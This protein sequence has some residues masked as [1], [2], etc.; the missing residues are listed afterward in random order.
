MIPGTR[1]DGQYWRGVSNR[2]HVDSSDEDDDDDAD[3]LRPSVRKA[4]RG[5]D[6]GSDD[7]DF[8]GF[9]S[10]LSRVQHLDD[11]DDVST[12][13]CC[14][15]VT[16]DQDDAWGNF[17]NAG[18]SQ[19]AAADNANP[20]DDFRP[21]PLTP[22]DW[23][24]EFDR[25]FGNDNWAEGSGGAPTIVVPGSDDEDDEDDGGDTDHISPRPGSTW[26]FSGEDEGEDLPPTLSPT[27]EDVARFGDSQDL[28]V[29]PAKDATASLSQGMSGLSLSAP[30]DPAGQIRRSAPPP[31]PP[32]AS[33]AVSQTP[34]TDAFFASK[35]P[36]PPPSSKS[37]TEP[38][39]DR[40]PSIEAIPD[41]SPAVEAIPDRSP[42]VE[43][44]AIPTSHR[45]TSSISSAG[46]AF[47]PPDASLLQATS[48]E[49]PLGPGVS[50]DAELTAGGMVSREVD[51]HVVTVPADEIVL[52]VEDA[53]E[54]QSQ[55]SE[56]RS[57]IS[58]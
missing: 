55:S 44:I 31:P 51:G 15:L 27:T 48:P 9:Q 54:R 26:S 13:Y 12:Q 18:P 23:A 3:W 47:S 52:G 11:F 1:A 57:P 10:G 33:A 35:P 17:T 29:G 40:R 34:R 56:G 46:Q 25:E 7:D 36:T 24:S 50:K 21:D 22:H 5:G 42:A 39:R 2:K 16:D 43:A 19:P 49:E 8:A 14:H 6:I 53:M 37:A 30:R 20:F 4:A 58:G 45:R 38:V 32:R 28:P 41:R